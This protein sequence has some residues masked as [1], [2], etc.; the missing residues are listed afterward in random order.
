M[1]TYKFKC[2]K[3]G[4]SFETPMKDTEQYCNCSKKA[5]KMERIENED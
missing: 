3:C 2:P 1:T 5:I 4:N